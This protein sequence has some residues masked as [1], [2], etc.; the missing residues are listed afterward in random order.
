MKRLLLALS[1]TA[2]SWPAARAKA[3]GSATIKARRQ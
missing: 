1:T 3:Q 2:S